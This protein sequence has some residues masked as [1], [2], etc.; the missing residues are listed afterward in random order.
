MQQKQENAVHVIIVSGYE[1]EDKLKLKPIHYSI[2]SLHTYPI[3]QVHEAVGG[4]LEEHSLPVRHSV[5]A[6]LPEGDVKLHVTL[7]H[8]VNLQ[9]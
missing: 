1:V 5:E 8:L 4:G 2:Q 9:R 6:E 7:G 3:S